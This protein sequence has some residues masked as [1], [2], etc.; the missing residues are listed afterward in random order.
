VPPRNERAVSPEAQQTQ[1]NLQIRTVLGEAYAFLVGEQYAESIAAVSLETL[2]REQIDQIQGT[3]GR[4][5]IRLNQIDRIDR[6]LAQ[7]SQVVD[8]VTAL[9]PEAFQIEASEETQNVNSPLDGIPE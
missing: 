5:S 2:M 9:P 6:M 3:S 4:T 8:A 7:L 1:L